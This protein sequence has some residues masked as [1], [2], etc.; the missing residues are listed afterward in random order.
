VLP[1][2]F[3]VPASATSSWHTLHQ[4]TFY[5]PV[6]KTSLI[7]GPILSVL[8]TNDGFKWIVDSKGLWR[9]DSQSLK[10]VSFENKQSDTPSPQIQA[11]FVTKSGEVWVGTQ[12]GLYRLNQEKLQLNAYEESLLSDVSILNLNIT[13]IANNKIF[14]FASDRSLFIFND[15]TKKLSG[16]EL[17]DRARIHALH[18]DSKH[19]LWVGSGQG[20]FQFPLVDIVS[21]GVEHSPLRVEVGSYKKPRI[22]S[23]LSTASGYLVVGTADKGLFV[24]NEDAPFRQLAM[25]TSTL[26]WLFT[27]S[28]I[29]PDLLLLGTFGQGLIEVNIN[30]HETRQFS[31]NPLQPS[32]LADDNIW[33]TFADS[34]GLVWI[35]AGHTLNIF[36]ANNQSIINIFGGAN[37][38]KSLSY[39]KVH[40]V[41]SHHGE[42]FVG[43]GNAG[44][45]ILS[46]VN[47]KI[48]Q[49]WETSENPV[50]TL[51]VAK[52]GDVYASSNFAS[53]ELDSAT[54]QALPLAVSTRHPSTFTTA[55]L[56]TETS[57]WLGGTDGL[58]VQHNAIEKQIEFADSIAERRIASL[59]IDENRL[60]IG[61]WQGLVKGD[62]Q[63]GETIDLATN[64][65]AH[66]ILKQQYISSLFV[67]DNGYLWV[68]TGS[69]G[70][71]VKPTYADWTQIESI[72]G[73][74]GNNIAAIAGES[75]D[76]IWVSTTQ[77]I[78]AINRHSFAVSWAVAAPSVVNAP[79]APSAATIT[80]ENDIVFGGINGLTI[81]D[82]DNFTFSKPPV[83][84]VLTDITLVHHDDTIESLGQAATDLTFPPLTKRITFEFAALDYL[85][86][87]HT[88]YRYRVIGLDGNWIQ[89]NAE[90]RL[91]VITMPQPGDYTLQIEYS[92]D[93]VTW[94]KNALHRKLLVMPAWYQ[95]A[96]AKFVAILC[97]CV[98]VYIGHLLGVKHHRHRQAFLKKLVN[99]RTTE[100]S[101]ANKQLSEQAA[102]LK[103]ASLT[104]PLTGLHNRRY[105]TQH[106]ERDI[107]LVQRY[108]ANC[109][110]RYT[111]PKNHYD[112]LFF[113]IDLDHF[114]NINDTYGHQAGD[115]VLVETQ[116]R[117]KR[118]FRETD[119]LIR[120][121][122]EE[123]LVVVHNTP[124]EEACVLAERAVDIVGSIEFQLSEETR[125]HVTCSI[126]YAA[127]PLSQQHYDIFDWQTTIGLADTAL[128]GAKNNCRNTWMGLTSIPPSTDRK[129]LE[130]VAKVPSSIFTYAQVQ[131]PN[132]AKL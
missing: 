14:T 115:K 77:G 84:V 22:S 102:A 126:G 15:K 20:L 68:G 127:Y 123:F 55:F 39:R 52:N 106:I 36:D 63:I 98:A 29:K 34:K 67:D 26:P 78:A 129:A 9:W 24:Q 71:F 16:F 10:S 116:K 122:G 94:E 23:I 118:I 1:L 44:I 45:E 132:S 111:E 85:T 80:N 109:D 54:K 11:T 89:A 121:G 6:A 100:L 108:Y 130:K 95:T 4:P 86:P 5:T 72:S 46:P 25:G 32:S 83:P 93:G 73:L 104:D 91:A 131:Q 27:M 2:F 38:D 79:Y 62:I 117:L 88:H 96:L 74:P 49:L 81:I 82:S 87:E 61:T 66:P 57:L 40:A 18:V 70:L 28:E 112:I 107:A 17:P 103:E 65:I 31:H 13:S 125:K 43:S 42:L 12:Q 7:D 8:E 50:E 69:A 37:I 59:A 110:Q 53:V 105:L 75:E 19:Q 51:H 99:A 97:L 114:K 47:G 120:W 33:S 48:E 119:Y 60:W 76:H 128:Y 113:V 35:G 124:R 56:S 21:S 58:W 64:Y 90:Q 92:Y 30:T 41:Q 3:C 101:I